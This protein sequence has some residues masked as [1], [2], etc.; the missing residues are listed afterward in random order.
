MERLPE[1]P[2]TLPTLGAP[3]YE[4]PQG[5]KRRSWGVQTVPGRDARRESGSTGK[6]TRPH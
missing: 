6:G 4:A 3:S 5:K 1:L 2:S